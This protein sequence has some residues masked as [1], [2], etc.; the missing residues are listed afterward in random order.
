VDVGLSDEAGHRTFNPPSLRGVSQ[1]GPFFHDGRAADLA[2]VFTRHR[3]QITGDLTAR[4]R[5]DLLAFLED[6]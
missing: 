2:E 3:H 6:L 1:A 5:D 4:E